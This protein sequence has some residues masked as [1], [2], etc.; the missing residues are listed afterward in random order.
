M[1]TSSDN[2]VKECL[3]IHTML[4]LLIYKDK[5]FLVIYDLKMIEPLNL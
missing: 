3:M 2:F 5:L 1:I 4:N